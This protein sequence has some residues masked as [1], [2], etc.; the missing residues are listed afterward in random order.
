MSAQTGAERRSFVYV[1]LT[2]QM[3]ISV[4]SLYIR[5]KSSWSGL[6]ANP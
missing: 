2:Q 6:S 5:E 3:A 4:N 1:L